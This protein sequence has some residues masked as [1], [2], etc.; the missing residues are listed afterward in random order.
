MLPLDVIRKYY[1]DL[2]DEDL[3]KIQVF[4][5]QLCCGLMKYFYEDEWEENSNVLD[6]KI[7]KIDAAV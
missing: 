1:P 7:K 3:N 5:Y 2:S 6:L 4:V